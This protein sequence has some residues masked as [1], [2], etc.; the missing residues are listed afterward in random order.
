MPQF[1]SV[2]SS[3]DGINYQGLAEGGRIFAGGIN[4]TFAEDAPSSNPLGLFGVG[5]ISNLNRITQV[6]LTSLTQSFQY[7][8]IRYS[9]QIGQSN[10][11]QTQQYK[12][13]K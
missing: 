6:P 13:M 11:P 4:T 1:I 10:P 7:Y 12:L 2:S 8:K 9:G 3:N 5:T